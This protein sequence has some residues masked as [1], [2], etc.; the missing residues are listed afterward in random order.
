MGRKKGPHVNKAFAY[1]RDR[2]ISYELLPGEIVSTINLSKELN[3]SR[4]PIMESILLLKSAGLVEIIN[5][6]MCVSPLELGDIIEICQ[7]RVAVECSSINI[8]MENGGLQPSQRQKLK[9]I[10][11]QLSKTLSSRNFKEHYYYDDLFHTTIVEFTKNKRLM[12]ISEMMR[13]QIQRAR[14]LNVALPNNRREKA[15]KEH[16][17]ILDAILDNN[18]EA[19]IKAIKD[20]ISKSKENFI[21]IIE[22]QNL[23][24]AILSI[25]NIYKNI[26]KDEVKE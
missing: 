15:H 1:I 23:R 2:I 21:K 13:L 19:C 18:E 25:Q 12:N 20:H 4:T 24:I 8:I 14:W 22:D 17:N 9:K 16:K 11:H 6:N 26:Y 5:D 10:F 7:V 3:M